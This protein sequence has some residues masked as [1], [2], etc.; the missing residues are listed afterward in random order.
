MLIGWSVIDTI[1]TWIKGPEYFASLGV[2][3]NAFNV[4]LAICG[5][6]GIIVRRGAVQAI[7]AVGQLV[8]IVS[9]VLR[10]FKI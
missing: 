5:I 3:A 8:Y 4:V 6:V 1:D 2:T 7:I 9:G 10:L